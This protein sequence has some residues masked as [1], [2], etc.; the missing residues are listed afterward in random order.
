[1]CVGGGGLLDR[2]QRSQLPI[3]NMDVNVKS[4]LVGVILQQTHH[5][6]KSSAAVFPA[7]IGC[8]WGR[9]RTL[10]IWA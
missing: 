6:G 4:E 10:V 1:M 7:V 8:Q 3:L 2:W 5:I 9:E